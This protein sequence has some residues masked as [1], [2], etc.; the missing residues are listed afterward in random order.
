MS[1]FFCKIGQKSGSE[2]GLSLGRTFSS[3]SFWNTCR[4]CLKLEK[5]VGKF[6]LEEKTHIRGRDAPGLCDCDDVTPRV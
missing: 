3:L 5:Y 1:I 4:V 6:K 2:G